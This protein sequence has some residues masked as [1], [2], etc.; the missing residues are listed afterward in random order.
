MKITVAGAGYVGLVTSVC[1]A[2]LGHEV[3][4][5][6]IQSEKIEQLQE[7]YSPIY[8]PEL[9]PL[10]QKNLIEG[11]LYFTT[12]PRYAYTHADV[13]FIAVGTPQHVDGTANLD[14]VYDV[15]ETIAVHIENDVIIC[16]KSTVPVGTNE[17]IKRM[18]DSK[19]LPQLR[20]EI[21]SNP[22]FLREGSA[23]VD[24]FYGDRIVIGAENEESARVLENIYQ[25]LKIPIIKTDV[26]S[27]E[28]IKYAS[29]A[30]LAT[31]ISFVNEIA[32]MCEKV[33]ANIDDVTYGIG[34]DQRIG[35]YFLKAG[36]GYGGSC[37]P[38]DTRAL[39]HTSG[40]LGHHF[41]LLEA[42]IKVNNR[43]KSFPV[44]KAKEIMP[45][46]KGKKV[47]VLGLSFK[48]NT[49]DI[50]EAASITV[51]KELLQE[52]ASVT[53]YDPIAIK[54]VKE[55]FGDSIDYTDEIQTAIYHADLTII[56]TEW[57]QIK[58]FPLNLYSEYMKEPKV[59]DG[60]NCYP[61]EEVQKY[62]LLYVSIGRPTVVKTLT[63]K[64]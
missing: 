19:K 15:I 46:L 59:I 48:P 21:V 3:I 34:K 18:I 41:E 29:N 2:E 33:G 40:S 39:M 14:Y 43:Q 9:E 35:P 7:G 62:P 50:R 22:E 47:A 54:N 38:K 44:V 58:Q 28:M 30:F 49:D 20:V 63:N 1:L 42:V 27:A 12:N 64:L 11:R 16:T 57:E 61:L 45:S 36:L 10:L 8:E 60:R 51:I 26:K 13:I 31:K 52:G 4:C 32:R 53:A 25:P 56:T 17:K 55:L 5:I 23:V 37:F 6:D 24:F